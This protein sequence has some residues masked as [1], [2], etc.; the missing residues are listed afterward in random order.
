MLAK[1]VKKYLETIANKLSIQE[2]LPKLIN[3][4]NLSIIVPAY[5]EENYIGQLLTH[6]NQQVISVN[7]EIIIV[8]NGSND[9]T[10]SIVKKFNNSHPTYLIQEL[11][12]GAGNARK[13]G[14][15]EVIRRVYERD[16][17][18]GLRKHY[19]AFTDADTKPDNL[20]LSD[21]YS[22]LCSTSDSILISGNYEASQEI[23]DIVNK[24]IGINNFFRSFSVLSSELDKMVGQTRMRGPNSGLE[25]ECYIK[26]GGFRQ[27][28]D[29]NG[30]TAP[31]ECF[32][33]AHRIALQGTPILHFDHTIIASQRRKLQEIIS[34]ISSYEKID[35][36]TKRFISNQEP[37]EA[38]L[39]KALDVPVE[40][41]IT[42]RDKTYS[43]IATN[44][45]LT[46]IYNNKNIKIK[47]VGYINNWSDLLEDTTILSFND[48]CDKWTKVVVK[49]TLSKLK[50]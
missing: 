10:V 27:P 32:D 24:K 4:I 47:N 29:N 3:E 22:L 12:R 49:Y 37:E 33:L 15:D 45:L 20:W 43:K 9:E 19:I 41:W 44:S 48:F 2:Q 30:N 7:F 46:P 50:L 21:M 17:K 6:L 1:D 8:D 14:V 40:A 38:I 11:K 42:Y 31:R 16:F 13:S 39:K 28:V 26:A 23:D 34:G 35:A 25:I 36:N 5:N 18:T